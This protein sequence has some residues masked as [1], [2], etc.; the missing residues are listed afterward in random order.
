MIH[1]FTDFGYNGPYVGEMKARILRDISSHI[2]IIDL[3]HD[4]PRFNPK[5]S[6]YLLAALSKQFIQNDTCLAVVDPGVGNPKRNAIILKADDVTYVGPDNGL[7]AAIISQ[8]TQVSAYRLKQPDNISSSFHGRDWFGPVV[9][10]LVSG[11]NVESESVEIEKLVGADMPQDIQEIVYI[12]H[13]GNAMTGLRARQISH[14]QCVSIG[15]ESI[16]YAR[17]FSEMSPGQ[18]FWYENS[19]GLIEIAV[20]QGSASNQLGLEIGDS[21]EVL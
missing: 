2:P 18:A 5:A 8:S 13:Y 16:A 14:A 20:N 1:L 11:E 19:A 15:S 4:A 12:D 10:S 21:L 7:F 6:A 17:T 9:T 3:M